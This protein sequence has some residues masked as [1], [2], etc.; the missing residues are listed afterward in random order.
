M[1]LEGTLNDHSLIGSQV[2][3]NFGRYCSFKSV[4]PHASLTSIIGGSS[5]FLSINDAQSDMLSSFDHVSVDGEIIK[6]GNW[7]NST[8][9]ILERGV[10]NTPRRFHASGANVFGVGKNEV[11]D[12]NFYLDVN[13]KYIYQ[14]RCL[15][16]RNI[17]P[18]ISIIDPK[19]LLD[20]NFK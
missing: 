6:I 20:N 7:N 3:Q 9:E 15:S 12:N 16:I 18:N 5:G 1:S 13:S 14:Y 17:Y 11:F 8:A 19:I 4:C 2:K 10:G